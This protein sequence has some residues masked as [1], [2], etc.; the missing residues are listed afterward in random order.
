VGG[1][2]LVG[3][4]VLVARDLVATESWCAGAGIVVDTDSDDIAREGKRWGG[5]VPFLRDQALARDETSTVDS[6]LAVLERLEASG[7]RFESVILLQPTSP[8]RIGADVVACWQSFGA[9][10]PSVASVSPSQHPAEHLL[11]RR[12]DSVITWRDEMERGDRR[13]DARPSYRLTGAVYVVSV[14]WLRAQ[15]KFVVGGVTRGVVTDES[16]SLDV[17]AEL[18]LALA[19][20]IVASRPIEPVRIGNAVIGDGPC[21]VIA[22][23]GVN[24]NGDAKLAHQ[25]VDVAADAGADAVKFQTFDPDSLV[26]PETRKADYQAERTGGA[27]SQLDMLR[28]LT[29]PQ[30]T[31]VELAKHAGDRGIQ[32]LSTAFDEGSADFLEELGVGAFKVPSGEI[33]NHGFLEHLARKK[34]PLLISTGMST[35][36]EVGAALRVVRSAGNPPVALFHCVTSY[37]ARP[38]DCNLAA[39]GT[40]R[41]AF[42]VPVGWSDHTLGLA[43]SLASVAAGAVMLEKH[44]TLDCNLP[45]PDHA[46]SLEPAQ[47]KEL[48][49]SLREIERARGDGIKR[50]AAAEMGNVAASRRSLHARREIGAGH[51]IGLNDLV[52][53][54]P[55]TGI[56]PSSY[57]ALVGRVVRAPLRQGE[58]LTEKHLD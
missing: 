27:E 52:A 38:Q 56:A 58:M 41:S 4:A 22:E 21:F 34:R 2:S 14:S 47:L 29:L 24:H 15:R 6:T 13:Q 10:A 35:L 31:F 3:R 11:E 54:R 8:L 25:L 32:F 18:D 42:G 37:P 48:M 36:D 51:V 45:G 16:R 26:A 20:A 57:P 9:D 1:I 30:K 7:R 43:V 12:A 28:K 53:L 50:P 55:G 44:M 40:M 46:A 5:E 39:M 33:T 17:D 23:A 19:E 49:T